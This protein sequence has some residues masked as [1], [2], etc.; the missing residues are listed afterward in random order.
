MESHYIKTRSDWVLQVQHNHCHEAVVAAFAQ[1]L[2]QLQVPN[3][4]RPANWLYL[5][6]TCNNL[7]RIAAWDPTVRE[8]YS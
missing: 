7:L 4:L 1:T 8:Y 2:L 5:P 6:D 3:T